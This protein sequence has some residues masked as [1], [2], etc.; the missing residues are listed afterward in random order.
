MISLEKA[1]AQKHKKRTQKEETE[2]TV[3][4]NHKQGE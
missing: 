4:N 2:V 3:L 1:A